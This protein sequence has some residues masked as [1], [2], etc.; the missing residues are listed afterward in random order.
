M[1]GSLSNINFWEESVTVTDCSQVRERRSAQE[2]MEHEER[3]RWLVTYAY[4]KSL[5]IKSKFDEAGVFPS[6]IR[7]IKDL[8]LI[9]VTTKDEFLILQRSNPPWWGFLAV[10]IFVGMVGDAAKVK[11]L[12]LHPK[13]LELAASRFTKVSGFQLVITRSGHRDLLTCRL[14]LGDEE[15]DRVKLTKSLGE[16]IRELCKLRVDKFEFL[17]KGTMPPGKVVL[18]ERSWI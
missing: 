17:P 15:I 6:Q 1:R 16:E 12:F 2:R 11:G 14:E 9:P 13:P 8:E 5:A 4:E 3:L 10:P 7:S 18:N